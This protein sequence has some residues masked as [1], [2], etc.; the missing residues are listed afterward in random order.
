M[1]TTTTTTATNR[2]RE[3]IVNGQPLAT[4]AATLA[5]LV[6]KQGFAGVKVAT[7]L[8]GDFVAERLRAATSLG[9]GDRIEILTVRQGG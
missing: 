7:A 1:D 2:E 3:I 9:A 5:E 8:N 6:D 4:A